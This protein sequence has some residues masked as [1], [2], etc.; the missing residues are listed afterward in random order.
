MA[1]I[2]LTFRMPE[3]SARRGK[4][5]PFFDKLRIIAL[6]TLAGALLGPLILGYWLL[7]ATSSSIGRG[8]GNF[9]SFGWKSAILLFVLTVVLMLVYDVYGLLDRCGGHGGLRWHPRHPFRYPLCLLGTERHVLK[10]LSAG[11]F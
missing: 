2:R 8:G 9:P 6:F 4:R 5:K 10:T 11:R 1:R 7:Q 3:P